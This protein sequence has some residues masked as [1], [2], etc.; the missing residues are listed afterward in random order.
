MSHISEF[1]L[2]AFLIGVG[3][4]L[5]MD[6]WALFLKRLGIPSLNFAFLGRW[7][8]HL[9]SRQ[10]THASIATAPPIKAE[11]WIGWFAHYSIGVTFAAL[12]LAAYGL[13]WARNPTLI[14]ALI[15]GIVTVVAPLF[16]LQPALGAGIASSKTP[17]PVFNCL[18][19]LTTHTVFGLGLYLAAF[20]TASLIR[21][22]ARQAARSSAVADRSESTP[23]PGREAG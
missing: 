11:L 19:S 23:L 1:V 18:K 14:P 13:E 6:L 20:A 8:G 17:T 15:I 3:A 5:V 7:I 10:W 22:P 4:T 12:L 2:R 9:R 21:S 16:L